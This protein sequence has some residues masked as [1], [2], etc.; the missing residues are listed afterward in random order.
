MFNFVLLQQRVRGEGVDDSEGP[1]RRTETSSTGPPR[2]SCAE[3]SN[4]GYSCLPRHLC[5]ESRSKWIRSPVF[6]TDGN[7]NVDP[8]TRFCPNADEVCCLRKRDS[9]S[10]TLEK[11][12][13]T[14]GA[15]TGS[16]LMSTLCPSDF[17]GVVAYPFDCNKFA[18]CW[19]GKPT[20]QNCAPGTQFNAKLGQCD[21]P[22]K[23]NCKVS[24]FKPSPSKS[25]GSRKSYFSR[26][27]A[28]ISFKIFTSNL[29]VVGWHL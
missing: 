8:T 22:H 24:A 10:P 16:G 17:S 11:S 4:L 6:G 2:P 29:K 27:K 12:V 14:T 7:N 5:A 25:K 23:A 3:V 28:R 15:L 26:E 13:P 21:F 18:N 1:S 19:K 20:I 9:V